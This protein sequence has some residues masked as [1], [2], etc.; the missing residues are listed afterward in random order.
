MKK[1]LE[2]VSELLILESTQVLESSQNSP[3][4]EW[5]GIE[6]VQIGS[7]G[8]FFPDESSEQF[9]QVETDK[10]TANRRAATNEKLQGGQFEALAWYEPFHP[11][12]YSNVQNSRFR[13]N[14]WGIFIRNSAIEMLSFE[15]RARGVSPIE[16]LNGASNFLFRHEATHFAHELI[17]TQAELGASAVS[18]LADIIAINQSSQG[19]GTTTEG[20]CNSIALSG[21]TP[22]VKR[23]FKSWLKAQPV[24]Y[25]DWQMHPVKHRNLSWRDSILEHRKL[26]NMNGGPTKALKKSIGL[27]PLPRAWFEELLDQVPV[28]FVPDG[29]GPN[30]SVLG[31]M[32]GAIVPRETESFFK[33]LESK[34]DRKKMRL[35]WDKTKRKLAAGALVSVH[36]EKLDLKQPTYSVQVE[37]NGNKGARAALVHE[38][39]WHAVAVDRDHNKLYERIKRISPVHLSI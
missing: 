22:E 25:R 15:L 14:R 34:G 32:L 35:A 24:G 16:A 4:D 9:H 21:L 20:L 31:A 38:S 26:H 33:D 3:S 18:Y 7:A 12:A 39:G 23:A 6:P 10:Q 29:L 28:H 5:P 1:Y 17:I 30:G 27:L 13:V 36:F 19:Y 11:F 2:A 37:G 8:T